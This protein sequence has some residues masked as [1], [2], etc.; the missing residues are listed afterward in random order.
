MF[1]AIKFEFSFRF[2]G[3]TEGIIGVRH[4][5]YCIYIHHCHIFKFFI[6]PEIC[7]FFIIQK[8]IYTQIDGGTSY[9]DT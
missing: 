2:G 1:A 4:V 6:F 5:K 8:L 7:I 9:D 3:D